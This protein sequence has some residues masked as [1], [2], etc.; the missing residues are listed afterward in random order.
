[1]KIIFFGAGYCSRFIIPLLPKKT[2]IICTHKSTL[3]KE[4][5]DENYNI[6]RLKLVDFKKNKKKFFKNTTH[7]LNSIPPG[8]T[9]DK[10]INHFSKDLIENAKKIKWYGYFSS[11]SVYGNHFGRWVHE[12]SNLMPTSKRGIMRYKAENEHLKIY[13]KFRLPVHIFRLPGIYGPGRSIFDKISLG[14]SF[15]IK[16][17]G[18]Y[19]SRI[20]VEDIAYAINKSIKLITPGETF[21]IVDDFPCESEKIFEYA[22]KLLNLKTFEKLEVEDKRVTNRISSFY[23]DNKKVSN[24]KIKKILN[25]TPKYRNYKLGLNKIYENLHQ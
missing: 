19:F 23:N 9:G 22:A 21:N 16:K 24:N 4:G 6:K 15:A 18:H 13:K 8:V 17:K 1:M 5:F 12:N 3:K 10:I 25:W 11:T 20:H 14:T 2:E 7:I